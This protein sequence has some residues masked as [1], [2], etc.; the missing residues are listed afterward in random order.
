MGAMAAYKDLELLVTKIQKQLA[1][2]AQVTHNVK[3][4]VRGL[5]AWLSN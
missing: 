4:P 1:P 2:N 3:L 5:V